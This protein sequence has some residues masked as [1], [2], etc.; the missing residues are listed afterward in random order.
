MPN[1]SIGPQLAPGDEVIVVIPRG[2]VLAADVR[3]YFK[4]IYGIEPVR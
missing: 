1:A 3:E 4:R 2:V